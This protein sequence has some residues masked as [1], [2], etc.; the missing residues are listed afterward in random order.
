MFSL[1][2]GKS[3]QKRLDEVETKLSKLCAEL[4]AMHD[5]YDKLDEKTLEARHKY[6]EK[7]RKLTQKYIDTGELGD[8]PNSDTSGVKSLTP[9]ALYI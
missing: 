6:T 7:L 1:W 2:T 4:S 9:E 8:S 5:K 3:Q